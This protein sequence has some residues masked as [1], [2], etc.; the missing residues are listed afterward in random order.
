KYPA[1][2]DAAQPKAAARI[3]VNPVQ[4]GGADLGV[5]LV[6]AGNLARWVHLPN[7]KKIPGV[8][9]RAIQSSSGS[10]AK[11]YAI[12]FGSEYCTSDYDEILNNPSVNV[13]VIV[14]RNQHHAS[15]TLAALQ[16]GEALFFEKPRAPTQDEGASRS[17]A[18]H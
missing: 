18:G 2:E 7:L 4:S 9:L 1:A 10:R 11:S 16:G 6:G 3:P 14:S 8:R 17:P 12:R 13:V 15:Q 5:A